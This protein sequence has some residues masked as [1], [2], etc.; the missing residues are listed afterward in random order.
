MFLTFN[1]QPEELA[2]TN[3]IE[4]MKKLG[5]RPFHQEAMTALSR[6]DLTALI[7]EYS[8]LE[9]AL[10]EACGL[11]YGLRRRRYPTEVVTTLQEGGVLPRRIFKKRR[12]QLVEE[13]FW[14]MQRLQELGVNGFRAGLLAGTEKFALDATKRSDIETRL[15]RHELWWAE[16]P[17]C[18]D[19]SPIKLY[20]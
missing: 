3:L 6:Q 15:R 9:A 4:L 8:S 12:K 7:Q 18:Y 11:L 19:D 20:G 1:R 13:Y 17:E 14:R 5:R 16:T 10:N 2:M